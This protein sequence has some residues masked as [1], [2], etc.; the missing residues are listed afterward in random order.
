MGY[1]TIAI[2]QITLTVILTASL[3]LWKKRPDAAADA[4]EQDTKTDQPLALRQI[5]SI[6]GAKEIFITFFCYCALEATAGLWGSSYLVLHNGV[7]AEDAARFAAMYYLG[8]TLGRAISGFV[9]MRLNDTHMVRLG[10]GIILLGVCA[11]LFPASFG[12]A[13]AGLVLMGLGSAPI[14]PCIIHSTPAHF[15]ADKSQAL[16]GV[17]MASAYTGACIMPPL[18]GLIADHITIAL[19]PAYLLILLAGMVW[20]YERVLRA[21]RE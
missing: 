16:I 19:F 4:K 1:R 13:P 9:T 10:E 8:I 12:L 18:F 15:G 5:L 2:L 17:Q 20:M 14:Y 3:P 7:G 11:F 21:V 6:A